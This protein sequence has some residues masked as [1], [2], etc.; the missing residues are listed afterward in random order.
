M[1]RRRFLS[2]AIGGCGLAAARSAL[3]SRRL[4]RVERRARALG[5]EVSLLVYHEE[6]AV[7]ER[8]ID[9]AFSALDTL[10]DVLS[11]YRP[12]SDLCRLNRAG[13]LRRPHPDLVVV[14][15]SALEWSR[16][17]RGAFDPTVQPLWNL[18]A[19]GGLPTQAELQESRDLVD[20]IRVRADS[21]ELRLGPGQLVTLNG[22]AQGFAADRVRE[23]LLA[24]GVRHAL[25][26]T[27]ELGS[28]G[29][30]PGSEEWKVGVQ[31]PRIPEAYIALT[32]LDGRFLAT[33]GDYETHFTED[34][35]SNHIFDPATGRSP[36]R[37]ASVSVLAHSGMEAD[38]L[39]TAVF[40]LGPQ[41]GLE[42]VARVSGADALLVMKDGGILSTS[43]FTRVA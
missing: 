21:G 24:H 43:N 33:S 31:H 30:K 25:V 37:L 11:L 22:I 32:P 15:S 16:R 7:A 38:A 18:Y 17:T 13:G 29:R 27:G 39:S 5:S 36:D 23:V 34:F 35:S 8:A 1:N 19:R 3:V 40:V 12:E 41:R 42:L 14:L 26:N 9:A 4:V 2:L 28:L 20:W 10:E 6:E